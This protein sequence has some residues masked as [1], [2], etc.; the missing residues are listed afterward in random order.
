MNAA[1]WSVNASRTWAFFEN[2]LSRAGVNEAASPNVGERWR[3]TAGSAPYGTNV[4]E[5][6]RT[7]RTAIGGLENHLGFVGCLVSLERRYLKR[8]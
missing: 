4:G 3:T 2:S 6:P 5:L 7:L 1:A 8:I